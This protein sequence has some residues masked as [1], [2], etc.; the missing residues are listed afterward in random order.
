MCETN[1]SDDSESCFICCTTKADTKKYNDKLKNFSYHHYT[2]YNSTKSSSPKLKEIPNPVYSPKTLT[3]PP[4]LHEP[5]KTSISGVYD[6]SDD[7][8]ID[9]IGA[10][11]RKE[12]LKVILNFR[13]GEKIFAFLLI[14]ITGILYCIST[15]N[16]KSE[17]LGFLLI[18]IDSIYITTKLKLVNCYNNVL[19]FFLKLLT[20]LA[21]FVF[22]PIIYLLIGAIFT[23]LR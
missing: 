8:W 2:E 5:V 23:M 20:F 3:P 6:D 14:V 13:K 21:I 12:E 4:K 15:S 22:L 10:S 16:S 18:F 9:S 17:A 11:K 1:N 7:K 19:K